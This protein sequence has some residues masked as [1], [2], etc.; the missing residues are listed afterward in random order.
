M[1]SDWD[2]EEWGQ[3]HEDHKHGRGRHFLGMQLLAELINICWL[4]LIFYK[5]LK[6]FVWLTE[7]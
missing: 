7:D 2:G 6:A 5:L 4:C 3:D 1:G